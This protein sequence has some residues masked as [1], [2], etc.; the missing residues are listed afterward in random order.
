[1]VLATIGA[2]KAAVRCPRLLR[3]RR[4]LFRLRVLQVSEPKGEHLGAIMNRK[5][6]GDTLRTLTNGSL[7]LTSGFDRTLYII[8]IE[9]GHER[10]KQNLVIMVNLYS[11]SIRST[12]AGI[13][14][15][16]VAEPALGTATSAALGRVFRENATDGR[17]MHEG[18]NAGLTDQRYVEQMR[19][20]CRNM[21]ELWYFSVL[22]L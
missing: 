12:R 1:M 13:R 4:P 19:V 9:S 16:V 18:T 22:G 3:M 7:E 5:V 11:I 17:I 20:G 2:A 10:I 8:H 21:A 15:Y 6:L 14:T